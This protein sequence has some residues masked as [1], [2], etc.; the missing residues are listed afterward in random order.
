M[1][2]VVKVR[3]EQK[4]GDYGDPGWFK[5]RAG[6]NAFEWT[7][8]LAQ[9]ARFAAEGGSSMPM[10]RKPA[11]DIEVRARKPTGGHAGH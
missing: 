6:T 10:Q 7:G 9:P 2:S 8:A 3:R 5:H 1:F 4:R 11:K